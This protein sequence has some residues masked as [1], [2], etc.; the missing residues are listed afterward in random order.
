MYSIKKLLMENKCYCYKRK[1]IIKLEDCEMFD[2]RNQKSCL[3]RSNNKYDKET[4][5]AGNN[6]KHI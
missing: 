6:S 2:C 4:K 5:D 1:E 3:T